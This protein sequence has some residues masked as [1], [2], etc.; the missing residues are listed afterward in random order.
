[1]P[2]HRKNDEALARKIT[3]LPQLDKQALLKLWSEI[4]P[5]QP[6][7]KLRK[8][9][10]VPLLAYRM[11]EAAYGGLS[12]RARKRLQA[13]DERQRSASQCEIASSAVQTGKLVR[14]WKGETYKVLITELG[15]VYRDEKFKSLSPIAKRITGTRWSG[16]AFFGTRPKGLGHD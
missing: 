8:E 13:L 7:E 2:E 5:N 1:M 6:I 16:P 3:K 11:Q 15:F 14:T 9:L 4:L 10:I 12:G